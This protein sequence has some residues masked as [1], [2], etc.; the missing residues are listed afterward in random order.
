MRIVVFDVMD[1]EVVVENACPRSAANKSTSADRHKVIQAA[2]TARVH[3]QLSAQQR[4]R[5]TCAT[6]SRATKGGMILADKLYVQGSMR[7]C[8][9]Q[10]AQAQPCSSV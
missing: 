3:I 5:A 10:G 8:L 1:P 6:H 4:C 9:G 2:D 7:L